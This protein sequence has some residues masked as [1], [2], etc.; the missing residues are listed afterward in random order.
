MWKF[1]KVRRREEVGL[2]LQLSA[3]KE[4]RLRQTGDAH[5]IKLSGER[6]SC[7]VVEDVEWN[8]ANVHNG[9]L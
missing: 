7:F 4:K 1:G 2:K 3:Q 5:E 9:F 6:A 8:E